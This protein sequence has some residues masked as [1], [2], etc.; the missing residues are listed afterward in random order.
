MKKFLTIVA[1]IGLSMGVAKAADAGV[2]LNLEVPNQVTAGQ[3]FT[4]TLTIDKQTLT[5]FAR[6]H[7]DLPRGFEAEQIDDNSNAGAVFSFADQRLR[8]IWATLPEES[9]VKVSYRIRITSA[10]LKGNL[11][12][13]GRFTYV[14]G[15]ERQAADVESAPIVVTPVNE[16]QSI[17]IEAFQNSDASSTFEAPAAAPA[18]AAQQ[19][20][21]TEE[22]APTA[23]AS[24]DVFVVRQKPYMVDK[25]YYVNLQV[26]KGALSGYG[27]I[28][29]EQ[30]SSNAKVEAIETKGAL[31]SIEGN[32]ISF[33]WINLP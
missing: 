1:A 8:L 16:Q 13:A 19:P 30:L 4:V 27:K 24:S 11:T 33:M 2:K 21:A 32:K 29:E 28:E 3:T 22:V 7:Q 17:D 20:T 18:Q 23:V 10:R 15:D 9:S 25:D 12:L 6:F 5:G 14:V 26:T 31:F